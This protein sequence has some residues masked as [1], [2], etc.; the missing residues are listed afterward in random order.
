MKRQCVSD[1]YGNTSVLLQRLGVVRDSSQ[2]NV[3]LKRRTVD[4]E[5]ERAFNYAASE[6]KRNNKKFCKDR[7]TGPKLLPNFFNNVVHAYYKE[8]S[9]S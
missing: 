9:P 3:K 7:G 5:Q 6:R 2:S 8:Y 1:K 4:R